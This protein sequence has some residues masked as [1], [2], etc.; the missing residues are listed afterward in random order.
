MIEVVDYDPAWMKRFQALR[1]EY[2]QAFSAARVPVVAV[3]HVGSTS[4]VGLAAKPII[5][6]DIVIEEPHVQA[7]STVLISLGF[8][9]LGELGIPQ[10]W[11]FD[12]PQR[13]GGTNT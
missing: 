1:F 3:E 6:C 4:V 2:V 8:I 10:R 13:L 5:D 9:P 12:E 7:A 11:A